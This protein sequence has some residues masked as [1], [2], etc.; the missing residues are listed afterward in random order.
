MMVF[1]IR[2]LDRPSFWTSLEEVDKITTA[3]PLEPL[4][5]V[6][7][8]K[9]SGVSFWRHDPADAESL[10]RIVATYATA[11]QD[12]RQVTLAMLS[13]L[14][15]NE[16]GLIKKASKGSGSDVKLAETAH[17]DLVVST[18][19]QALRMVDAMRKS[20]LPIKMNDVRKYLTES[21]DKG[22]ITMDKF[23]GKFLEA[24]VRT[25]MVKVGLY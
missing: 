25:N 11:F 5:D 9:G 14:D 16:I 2:F 12:V 1:Y 10:P 7:I 6:G 18:V 21:I 4:L 13:E 22:Y 24:M 20:V 8:K 15:L 23:N 3:I 19:E 17:V